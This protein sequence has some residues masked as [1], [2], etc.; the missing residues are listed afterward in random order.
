MLERGSHRRTRGAVPWVPLGALAVLVLGLS[1]TA[2]GVASILRAAVAHG[3]LAWTAFADNVATDIGHRLRVPQHALDT[4]VAM[5]SGQSVADRAALQRLQ[6]A[7]PLASHYPGVQALGLLAVQGAEAWVATQPARE[8]RSWRE[9]VDDALRAGRQPYVVREVE[10]FAKQGGLWGRDWSGDP[11]AAD[12]VRRAI[13][14]G[15][16]LLGYVPARDAA[17]PDGVPLLFLAAPLQATGGTRDL[18][19]AVFTVPELLREVPVTLQGA[20]VLSL[21]DEGAEAGARPLYTAAGAEEVAGREPLYRATQALSFGGRILA[22]RMHS[23]PLFEQEH[24]GHDLALA[25]GAAGVL[26]SLMLAGAVLRGGRVREAARLATRRLAAE[27]AQM[28]QVAEASRE[29]MLGLDRRGVVRWCN[30]SALGLLGLP[31][32]ALIGR[33]SGS[34][35]AGPGGG[36][37]ALVAWETALREGRSL[38]Q[39]QGLQGLDGG[40]RAVQ[41][42]LVP[43][44]GADGE[45]VGFVDYLHDLTALKATQASLAMAVQEVQGLWQAVQAHALVTVTDLTGRITEVNEAFCRVSGFDREELIGQLHSVVS[46][47]VHPV[48]FWRDMWTVIQ[49]GHPWRG[50]VCNR[51]KAGGTFWVD[52]LVAPIAGL[53]GRP[54]RFVCIR[55]VNTAAKA[56]TAKVEQERQMLANVLA[57]SDAGTWE[58]QLRTQQVQINERWAAM[59]GQTVDALQPFSMDSWQAMVHPVDLPALNAAVAAHLQGRS[60]HYECEFRLRHADPDRWV[61]V[62]ARGLVVERDERGQPLVFAGVHTDVTARR[63]AEEAQRSNQLLLTRIEHLAG[64]GGWELDLRSGR[65]HWST[66]ALRLLA[67]DATREWRIEDILALM[68]EADRGRQ[69]AAIQVALSSSEGWDL[70]VELGLHDGRRVWMRSVG[71]AEY[72][73]SGPVR[74]VGALADITERRQLEADSKRTLELLRTVLDS[75]PCGVSA[76]GPDLA[77]VAYNQQL[78]KLLDI[79]PS[80]LQGDKPA[81][82]EDVVR[83]NAYRGE[84]GELADMEAEVAFRMNRARHPQ[85]RRYERVRPTGQVLEV[86][87]EPMAGGGFVT[88]Y[89]DITARRQAEAKVLRAEA[90]LRGAIDTVNEAFVLFDPQDRLVMCNDKYRQLYALSADL[91]VPGVRFEDLIRGGLARGQYADAAGREEEWLAQRMAAHRTANTDSVQHLSDGRWVRI[92]ES[93][94]PDGHTV[95]FR[96]DI[97]DLVQARQEAESAAKAKGL[98]VANMSHEIR[99]PMNA[100]L[101][102]LEL[103]QRTALTPQQRDYADK[104]QGAARSLLGLLNDILDFSKVEAGKMVLDP[105]PFAVDSLLQDLSVILAVSASHKPVELLFDIDP[106]LPPR[107][108]AD[109]PRLQQ[110]LINLAGNAVKFTERGNV[111]LQM[112]RLGESDGAVDV[113]VA[114]QDSGIGIAPEHQAQIFQG[115]T[116]AEASTSRRFGGTGLGLAISQRLVQLM[117]GQLQLHSELGKGSRFSFVLRLPRAEGEVSAAP[118]LRVLLVDDNALAREVHGV[119]LRAMGWQVDAVATGEEAVARAL[120][121]EGSDSPYQLVLV[122]WLMPGLDGWQ[123]VQRLR[124][125]LKAQARPKIVMLT[126]Q[127][128]DALQQRSAD[129]QSALDGFLVK[130][131]TGPMVATLAQQL[132]Q[133]PATAGPAPAPPPARVQRLEGLRI[134]LAE[135]NPI[136]QRVASELLGAEG[137]EITVAADGRLAV[138]LLRA[139]ADQFDVVLMDMQMPVMDG[140]MATRC[141]RQE[142]QLTQLPIVAM[143]AN[144]AASD[145]EQC[146]AAG[147]NAHVGKPFDLTQLVQL[148]VDLVPRSARSP[149]PPSA[150]DPMAAM[151]QRQAAAEALV[152]DARQAE[153]RAQGLGLREALGRMMGKTELF[154]RMVLSYAASAGSL[155]DRVR[156]HREA[157]DLDEAV[158]AFH[159]FKGLSAT[160]GA[161]RVAEWAAQGEAW[162]RARQWPSDEWLDDLGVEIGRTCTA[163]RSHSEALL[164]PSRPASVD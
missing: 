127:G 122:D 120:A 101:G 156:R 76:V 108:V 36:A 6:V 84:Y 95:G 23:T 12:T 74:L 75:L 45:V 155:V 22:L 159:G 124:A 9:A 110:V 80:L 87:S 49:A 133:A 118:A 59:L 85:A 105:Q 90:L 46:S 3:E 88:V 116:Q 121:A 138:D 47:G 152:D 8:G 60:A 66:E 153:A 27:L 112:R 32:E 58:I 67:L 128:R 149:G 30:A 53:D 68:P 7:R 20:A 134:L 78:Q 79:P 145:R 62:H 111:V 5:S 54:Q 42:Q 114:V 104:T 158:Q 69:S 147:M 98:F 115:F 31:R 100:I 4:V 73:D 48:E 83:F 72:D 102:M 63:H 55:F 113:E 163:L 96:V 148:L 34:L 51:T 39:E 37:D 157:G 129:E 33:S 123:V 61:W 82:F 18:G 162:A 139:G 135:D 137:A 103:L 15:E 28:E 26:V 17:Q 164:S 160:L 40:T 93:R 10:P 77:I 41:R 143:T 154:H 132:L 146:L 2:W 140:L 50:D 125:G 97:T 130:P 117:G 119:M 144:A 86:Q 136:N 142:L 81:N 14:T 11:A 25:T 52:S 92:V 151:R 65:S 94:M 91:M 44:H 99:T 131:I 89:N 13:A 70:E 38:S 1:L 56:L 71:E 16:A 57:A 35:L 43:L 21:W 126:G 24:A 107:L 109:A 150:P 29:G 141:I 106:Q 64:V 161:V 19:I